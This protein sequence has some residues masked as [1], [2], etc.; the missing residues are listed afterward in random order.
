MNILKLLDEKLNAYYE[1][2]KDYPSIIQMSKET[3]DKIFEEIGKDE[4]MTNGWKSKGN[5]YKGIK[6]KIKKDTFLELK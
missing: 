2:K 1:N 6:I 3:K 5:N 4:D